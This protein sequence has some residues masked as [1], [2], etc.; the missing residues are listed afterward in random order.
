METRSTI[1]VWEIPWTE[2]PDGLHTVRGVAKSLSNRALTQPCLMLSGFP[3]GVP[4][5]HRDEHVHC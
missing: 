3:A 4:R 2:E 5:P 1:L